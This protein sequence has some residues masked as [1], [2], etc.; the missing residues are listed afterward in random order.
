MLSFMYT[1]PGSP[2]G[3]TGE[4]MVTDGHPWGPKETHGDPWGTHCH[5][6]PPM[7]DAWGDQWEPME[8][9]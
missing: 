4:L 6:R 9:P 8:S 2:W 1:A 5:G 7:E 3:P